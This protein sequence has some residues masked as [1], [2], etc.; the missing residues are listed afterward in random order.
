VLLLLVVVIAASVVGF[1]IAKPQHAYRGGPI[2]DHG[3]F[4]RPR[5]A[6]SNQ[7]V[8]TFLGNTRIGFRAF[9]FRLR[10]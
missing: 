8:W 7:F 2:D 6:A 10:L 9:R 3:F 1:T 5:F 4:S